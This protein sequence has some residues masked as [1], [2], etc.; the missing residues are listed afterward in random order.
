MQELFGGVLEHWQARRIAG[1]SMTWN[2]EIQGLYEFIRLLRNLGSGE[3]IIW[4]GRI[5]VYMTSVNTVYNFL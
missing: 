3:W 4:A 2:G 5:L 1:S